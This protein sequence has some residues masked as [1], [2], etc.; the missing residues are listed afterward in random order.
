VLTGAGGTY[1][2]TGLPPGSYTV[3]EVLQAGWTQSVP[4]SGKYTLALSSRQAIAGIDFGNCP[5]PPAPHTGK[6][7][8]KAWMTQPQQ[9]FTRVRVKDQFMTDSLQLIGIDYLSNPVKKIHGLDTFYITK[10]DNHL[11]W[12][13]VVEGKKTMLTVQYTNQFEETAVNI[14]S[15][16]YLL[17][18]TWK[19]MNQH[20]PPESLDH[21]KAYRIVNP[22]PFPRPITLWDQFDDMMG[23]GDH[24]DMLIPKYFLTPA[25][26]NGE[27]MFDTVTHYV[28]YEILPKR[29]FQLPVNTS[30]Q[31]GLHFLMVN[32][33]DLLLVPTTRLAFHPPLDSMIIKFRLGWNMLSIPLW[34]NNFSKVTLFPPAVSDAF[35]YEGS[36]VPKETLAV[37]PG[38]WFKFNDTGHVHIS[39]YWCDPETI[40]VVTGWNM[41][42][43]A[44]APVCTCDVYSIPDGIVTSDFFGYDGSGY[45]PADTLLPNKGYWVKVNAGGKLVLS[46]SEH[47]LALSKI[48]IVPTGELPPSPPGYGINNLKATIPNQF[49]IEQNYRYSLPVDGWVTIK[50]HNV[51]GQEVATLMDGYQ[52]AGY[53]AVEFDAA[54]LPSGIY[55]YQIIAGSFTQIKKMVLLR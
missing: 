2:I 5:P 46:S 54:K 25:M 27:Q 47:L 1:C 35:T 42:G 19:H 33:S 38:Y 31:F 44:S 53:K 3:T 43:T 14:D 9:F 12:Y 51:L 50:V 36:Y 41:I 16:K 39:G 49:E 13:R 45:S 21:Y 26:K 7:H 48:K 4:P 24:I 18:P 10:P 17:V 15:V 22:I 37:G 55:T 52:N 40:D 8:Y 32:N 29:F 6:N 23:I 20:A 28:A 30:D 34:V 11:T